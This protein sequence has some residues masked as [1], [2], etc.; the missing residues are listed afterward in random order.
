MTQLI[1]DK[2]DRTVQDHASLTA[3]TKATAMATAFLLEKKADDGD[4][5]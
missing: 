5:V 2:G 1:L 4:N 3:T